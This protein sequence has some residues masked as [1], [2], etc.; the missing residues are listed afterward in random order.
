[1]AGLTTAVGGWLVVKTPSGEIEGYDRLGWIAVAS[2]LFSLWLATR[3]L[4][5]E[6]PKPAVADQVKRSSG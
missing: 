6:H 4:D 1:M 5:V 2:G 3:V